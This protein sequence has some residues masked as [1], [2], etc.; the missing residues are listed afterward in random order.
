VKKLLI[1]LGVF[2]VIV[3]VALYLVIGNLDTI[4]KKAIEHYGSEAT[5]T[6]VRVKKVH[7]DLTKGSGG[8]YGLTIANPKGFS[9]QSAISL[10]EASIKLNLKALSKDL[11][12]IDRITVS[13]PEVYYEMDEKRQGSLNVL[14]NNV[15]KS[16]PSGGKQTT[17]GETGP[18]LIIRKLDFNNGAI[19]AHIVP[20]GDKTY[21]AKLPAI[22]MANLGAPKG[23]TGG[24]IAKEV[25]SRLIKTARDE[26]QRQIVDRYVNKEL[27]KLK[28]QAQS[29]IESEK[30]KAEQSAKDKAEQQLKD[31]LKR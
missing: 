19:G 15:S 17:G 24:E 29:R 22:R 27:D 23:A 13:K 10:A 14:Y 20:L 21:S 6:A 1:A 4:V 26:V 28:G 31:L 3:A 16:I 5:Q 11:V 12:V 8:I 9:H 7:I 30:K 18:K 2:V 25:L